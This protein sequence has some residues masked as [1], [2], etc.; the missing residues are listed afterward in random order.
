MTN[1]IILI[2]IVISF[3]I[4]FSS[5]YFIYKSNRDKSIIR[6]KKK[7]L[8]LLFSNFVSYSQHFE[9]FILFFLFYNIQKGFYIDVGAF[10]PNFISVT[11]AFYE[12]GWYGINIEP[13]P[14]KYESLKKHRKRDTI[15]ESIFIH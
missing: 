11:K 10:D 12:R 9:D 8:N 4:G 5:N 14:E 3:I 2:F 13:I 15:L 7:I 1:K 6:E